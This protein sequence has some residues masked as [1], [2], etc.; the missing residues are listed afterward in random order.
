MSPYGQP[1]LAPDP[2]AVPP[3]A[4]PTCT[5]WCPACARGGWTVPVGQCHVHRDPADEPPNWRTTGR[6]G[7]DPR[8]PAPVRPAGEQG[9]RP[10]GR[11]EPPAWWRSN[12]PDDCH[13]VESYTEAMQAF[14]T[15]AGR[16]AWRSDR[17]ATWRAL[18]EA[19][20]RHMRWEGSAAGTIT[21][22]RTQVAAVASQALG[23]P[24]SAWTVTRL[25]RWARRKQL[26]VEV[27][28][29]A[30]GA[31]LS[32]L[33]GE[34]RG[35]RA[36]TYAVVSHL[37]PP[38]ASE[39]AMTCTDAELANPTRF[40]DLLDPFEKGV[41]FRRNNGYRSTTSHDEGVLWITPQ[42]HRDQVRIAR[43]LIARCRWRVPP[44]RLAR[45]LRRWWERGWC[46]HAVLAALDRMPGGERY[47]GPP[48]QWYEDGQARRARNV[49]GVV[50]HRLAAWNG[51][52]PPVRAAENAAY[53]ARLARVRAE[54]A[55]S[56]PV[57]S[58]EHR[59]AVTDH[60]RRFFEERQQKA[61]G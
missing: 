10:D 50:L 25:W 45:A 61:R 59:S 26:V 22:T 51:L 4:D 34:K 5:D 8:R 30:S 23:Y 42:S 32:R 33:D 38:E 60:L 29:P 17:L 40:F 53:T 49:I 14:D 18:W 7:S 52:P 57:A 6:S 16:E 15:A 31:F 24:V 21:A 3:S 35:N 11:F 56:G 9:S 54:A 13:V 44:A 37:P 43:A 27:E 46:G 55:P 1:A 39:P 19:W 36:G 58:P 2:P 20:M 12:V 47:W 28:A 48:D 41:S